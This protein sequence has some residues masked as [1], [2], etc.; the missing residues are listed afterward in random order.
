MVCKGEKYYLFSAEKKSELVITHE[1]QRVIDELDGFGG[2][3]IEF[4]PGKYVLSTVFLKSNVAFHLNEGVELLGT[5]NFNDYAEDEKLPFPVYQDASHSYFHCSMFVAEGCEN[6]SFDGKGCIDMRS[7][8]DTENKRKMAHRGAKCI[9]LKNCSNVNIEGITIRNATDLAIYFAGCQNVNIDS[10]KMRVYIDGISPDNSKNVTIRNCD[11]ECGDDGIVFKSSYNLNRLDECRNILVEKCVVK[12]RC[13]A[14]KIG[15]ET[16]GGF[17]DMTIRN[18]DIRET[19]LGGICIESTDGADIDNILISDITMKNVGT[20]IFIFLGDRLRG[21]EGTQVGSIENITIQNVKAEGP[22]VPY[23]VIEWGY[24]S[25]KK[26]DRE[27]YPW[28]YEPPKG[29]SLDEC[30]KMP[31]GAWQL[32]SNICGLHNKPI[33]NITLR[34]LDLYMDGGMTT[35]FNVA[36]PECSGAYPD[37]FIYGQILKCNAPYSKILP[38]SGLYCRYVDGLHL[39]NVK[40]TNYRADSRETYVFDKVSNLNLV[41]TQ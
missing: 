17:K 15:T 6:I 14:I 3:E 5:L 31:S 34:N 8:W 10:V 4:A 7:V 29:M 2:G 18:I 33:K 28:Y 9:A 26:G 35:D 1:L 16:N 21:P 24:A 23:E 11:I 37:V 32:A 19:R 36:V 27:Q 40:I 39:D 30:R 41:N 12:S 25:Y 22:Y 13:N 38:A 20:P